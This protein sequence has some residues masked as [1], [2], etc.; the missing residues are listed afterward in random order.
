MHVAES[1]SALQVI[2]VGAAEQHDHQGDNQ[3]CSHYSASPQSPDT[4]R[5]RS[6]LRAKSLYGHSSTVERITP[7]RT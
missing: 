6:A 3:N 5:G 7:W 4:S 2:A 1:G